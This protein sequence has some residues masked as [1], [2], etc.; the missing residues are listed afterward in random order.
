MATEAGGKHRGNRVAWAIMLSCGGTE[1]LYNIAHAI[2][3]A[4]DSHDLFGILLAVLYGAA[5]VTLMVLV[6]HL[7]TGRRLVWEIIVLLAVIAFAMGMSAGAVAEV[8]RPFAGPALCWLFP[9]TLDT[10]TLMAFRFVVVPE[11]A[12][13]GKHWW[14]K[15]AGRKPA[16]KPPAGRPQRTTKP[17]EQDEKPPPE[18]PDQ[19]TL[20]FDGAKSQR[21]LMREH[22]DQAVAAGKI[23]TGGDLNRAIGKPGTYSLGKKWRSR[24]LAELPPE[25]AAQLS[26]GGGS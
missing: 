18:V 2:R 23:P 17:P 16:T 10:A 14:T 24:W 15:T 13:H 12:G 21:D 7:A 8:I 20:T 11:P 5:A 1:L 4:N 19:D 9:A 22:W 26:A 6:S 3:G 25:Q